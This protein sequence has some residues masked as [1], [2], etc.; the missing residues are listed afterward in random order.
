MARMPRGEPRSVPDLAGDQYD[1]S[2]REERW[3]R[4]TAEAAAGKLP[5]SS[6]G[7]S[8]PPSESPSDFIKRT[9]RPE[10]TVTIGRRTY[11]GVDNGGAN[12]LVPVGDPQVSP[13]ELAERRRA[14][15]RVMFM[16]DSPLGSAAYDL[17]TAMNASP[18][19]RDAALVAGGMVDATMTGA[20]PFGVQVRG[21][22]S[23]PKRE[24]GPL[25]F[26]RPP[27]RSRSVNANGQAQGKDVT[28]TRPMLGTGTRAN[29]RV[30]PPGW[31]GHGTK[32]NEG[33]GHLHAKQLGGSGKT[34]SD[35]VTLTQNPTNSSHMATFEN[36]V[37]RRV[38]DGEVMEYL[39]KPLYRDGILP[40]RSI[41]MSAY[42]SRGA[43]IARL[44]EN[45]AGRRK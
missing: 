1:A 21:G 35:L 6:Y 30:K 22:A 19:R 12:V 2:M 27:V 38:R 4:Q 43:P 32:F 24:S 3:K 28:V 39:V 41:L 7:T 16:A 25:G 5:F 29:G 31:Q 42:G 36:Q 13:A 10:P 17:A 34:P 15:S 11:R 44:I 40:P 18:T 20:A 33:R 45:P 26:Q 9:P 23:P 8:L 37:M 14:V